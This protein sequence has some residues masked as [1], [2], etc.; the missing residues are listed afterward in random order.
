MIITGYIVG[1]LLGSIVCYGF[2]RSRIRTLNDKNINQAQTIFS[3]RQ[4]LKQ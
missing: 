2:M 1:W 3:L 4:Q